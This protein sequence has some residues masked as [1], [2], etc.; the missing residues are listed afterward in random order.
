MCV[1]DELYTHDVFET[2]MF[3]FF[4]TANYAVF[5]LFIRL[6]IKVEKTTPN[7]KGCT[8]FYK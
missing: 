3:L 5:C 2:F 6:N 4:V 7:C 1:E 8:A